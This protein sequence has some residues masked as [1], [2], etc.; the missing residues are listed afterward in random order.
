MILQDWHRLN[1]AFTRARG[2]LIMV[3]SWGT[4]MR[5]P[6]LA[7]LRELLSERDWHMFIPATALDQ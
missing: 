7:P 4:L 1:V 3:G 6:V 5:H 2:K